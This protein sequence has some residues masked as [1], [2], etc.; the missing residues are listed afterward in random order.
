MNFKKIHIKSFFPFLQWMPELTKKTIQADLIAGITGAIVVLPQGVAF[1]MIAGMPP[2]YGLYTAMVLP[3]VAALFGSSKHLISGPTTAISIVVF[4]AVS[5]YAEPGTEQFVA[6]ALVVTLIAGLF[7]FAFGLA[8]LGTLV[9]FVSHTVVIGFTAGAA[10]LIASSQIKNILSISIPKGAT[11][12]ETW[13]NVFFHGNETNIYALTIGLSTLLVA[14]LI[15]KFAPKVPNML[16]AMV[17]GG[18]LNYILNGSAEGV[19]LVGELPRGLPPFSLPGI[20]LE[21]ISQLAPNAFA[22][23]LLGLIEAVA[24]ARSIASKSGQRIDGN[25]EFIGQGLSNIIGSFFSSYAGSGSFTRSGV[26]YSAGAQ[27]PVAAIFAAILL[28]LIVTF[29]APLA[30]F[31]PIPAMG[32]I[33][34]LVSYNLIDFHHIKRIFSSSKRETT[35]LLI[36]LSSTLLLELEYAIYIGVIFSLIFY[37][38]QTSTPRFVSL[39]P[40]PGSNKRKMQNAEKDNLME[41]PQLKI[42]RIE[43]SLFFGAVDHVASELHRL[44]N[45]EANHLLIVSSSI[46]L[47]DTSG[48]EMLERE[49]IIWKQ[50][51]GGLYFSG[52][53]QRGRHT[54]QRTGLMKAIGPDHFFENK[55]EAIIALYP[56][57]SQDVCANCK[58]KIFLECNK[59]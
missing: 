23:A 24:I 12:I 30:A 1:A 34:L 32:G 25:Q 27:T 14:I 59:G 37:L 21:K 11:F 18:L 45:E 47:I 38:Q 20:T 26:N 46:N 56:K 13:S 4:S 19:A 49:A 28:M 31:L 10:I 54:M 2:I 9:N 40:D 35:V 44:R 48:A 36:T 51:G 50:K 22:I 16:V 17:F 53:K 55:E 3:I 57:L 5:Q 8:R 7:Q 15:K 43:G 52:L 58:K 6:L 41:C 42:I 39:A 29:V 33:I